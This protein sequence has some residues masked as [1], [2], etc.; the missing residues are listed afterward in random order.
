MK[1]KNHFALR[2]RSKR[3]TYK[4]LASLWMRLLGALPFTHFPYTSCPAMTSDS[5]SLDF[6]KKLSLDNIICMFSALSPEK[7]NPKTN[8]NY[9]LLL[10]HIVLHLMIYLRNK[11]WVLWHDNKRICWDTSEFIFTHASSSTACAM[12]A[13]AFVLTWFQ[14]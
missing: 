9:S 5:L 2:K 4:W 8:Q 1:L 14:T 10:P 7:K 11:M 6:Q 12:V 13:P 3:K